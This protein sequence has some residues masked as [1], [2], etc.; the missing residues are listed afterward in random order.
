MIHFSLATITKMASTALY[1]MH[2]L[3]SIFAVLSSVVKC[4]LVLLYLQLCSMYLT[5]FSL[6]IQT[7]ATL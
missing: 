7:T 1:N 3:L 5:I 6:Q 4:D 2:I